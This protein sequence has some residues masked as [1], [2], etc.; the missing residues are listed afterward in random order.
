MCEH[1]HY[2]EDKT[3]CSTCKLNLEC[4]ANGEEC[5]QCCNCDYKL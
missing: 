5:C 4:M 2:L 3:D 1:I